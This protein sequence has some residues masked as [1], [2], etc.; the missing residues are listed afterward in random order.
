MVIF[1][2]VQ[3]PVGRSF[4]NRNKIKTAMGGQWITV[5]VS[6]SHSSSPKIQEVTISHERDWA[7][8]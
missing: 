4:R 1:D 8:K 2:D 6:V 3:F 7:K 5:P